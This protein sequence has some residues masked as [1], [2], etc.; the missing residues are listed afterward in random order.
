MKRALLLA[1]L[2]FGCGF[3][4]DFEDVTDL[5]CPCDPDHVC[6]E[7]SNRCVRTRSVDLFKSC[8]TDTPLGGDE[9]CPT[10]NDVCRSVN[11]QGPRCLPKCTPV[12][13]A[14]TSANQELM[15]QCPLGTTCWPIDGGGG[16]CSEGICDALI[17]DCPA[18]QR[19]ADF[20]G[21]GVCFTPC[22]PFQVNPFPCAGGQICHPIGTAQLTACVDAGTRMRTEI[23][24][25]ENMCAK[26]DELG[27]PMVCAK[28]QGSTS[29]Q[30]RCWPICS[31]GDNVRCTQ[32]G[33]NCLLARPDI[34]P[35]NGADLG[36]CEAG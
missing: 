7:G 11:E 2:L 9:L 36:I 21:A 13:Y 5:P 6:L 10:E 31:P 30:L 12:N 25:S 16:V 35:L 19:C 28:P 4:L 32:P 3:I 18:G 29:S 22:D 24:D 20:N 26:L 14:T 1:P 8:P 17:Q 23:C 27:R 34:N 33:E 15:A